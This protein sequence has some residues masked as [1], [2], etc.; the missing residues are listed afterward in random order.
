MAQ[1]R[2][3]RLDSGLGFQVKF[4]KSFQRVCFLLKSGS[5]GVLADDITV[6]LIGNGWHGG[7]LSLSPSLPLSLSFSH[8]IVLPKALSLSSIHGSLGRTRWGRL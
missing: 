2:R 1:I 3:S 5:E 4:I 7:S 6:L 8:S